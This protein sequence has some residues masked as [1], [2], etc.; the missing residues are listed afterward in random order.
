VISSAMPGVDALHDRPQ[1]PHLARERVVEVGQERVDLD[2]AVRPSG[3]YGLRPTP[4]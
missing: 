1:R 3:H 4:Q 2:R